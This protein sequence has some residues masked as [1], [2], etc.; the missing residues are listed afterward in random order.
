ME[1]NAQRKL[2]QKNLD[3]IVATQKKT[4][5]FPFGKAR[6]DLLIIDKTGRVEQVKQVTKKTLAQ[7][8]LGKIEKK[9]AAY[10]SGLRG[11]SVPNVET[12]LE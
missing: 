5:N 2:R 10:P 8:L 9:K 4:N 6:L 12:S 11:R 1:K 3:L 7:I